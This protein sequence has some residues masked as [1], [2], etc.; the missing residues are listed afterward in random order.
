MCKIGPS[1]TLQWAGA[2][3]IGPPAFPKRC[4]ISH[5]FPCEGGGSHLYGIF[6]H[7]PVQSYLGKAAG[8][9]TVIWEGGERKRD[10]QSLLAVWHLVAATHKKKVLNNVKVFKKPGL[11]PTIVGTVEPPPH[12]VLLDVRNFPST[13]SH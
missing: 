10:A 1:I 4:I 9:C 6:F 8:Q 12:L 13:S 2:R 5:I 3:N 11:S 7:F